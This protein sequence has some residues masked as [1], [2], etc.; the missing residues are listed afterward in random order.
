MDAVI[1][2]VPVVSLDMMRQAYFRDGKAEY[3]DVIWWPKGATWKNQSLATNTIVRYIYFF[4]NTN[5]NGPV[6][7][8]LP[9]AV[10]G[11]AGFYGTIMDAWQVPLTDVGVGGKGGKYLLLPPDYK[12]EVP[13]GYI[14]M[15]LKTYNSYTLIRSILASNSEEDVRK[16]D[17]LVNT[18][19]VYPLSQAGSPPKQRFID[20]TDILYEPA[21]PY[22]SDF[23]CQ[24]R[25]H[26]QRGARAGE[27]SGDA[28]DAPS[29]RDREGQDIRPRFRNT[30]DAEHRGG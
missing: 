29:A 14:P 21:V 1:W 16:G 8:E 5:K 4:S 24:S 7:F 13:S 19:K 6:V 12:G 30:R 28:G 15:R 11:A 25:P 23:L 18:I 27:G 26:D 22:N 17:A 2:G 10:P 9:P 3:N 20:M